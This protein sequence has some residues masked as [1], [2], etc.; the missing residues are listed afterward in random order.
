[1]MYAY[2]DVSMDSPIC[3]VGY[4]LKQVES[5]EQTL[6]ETGVRAINTN[7]TGV[8]G[9]DCDWCSMRGE[10]LGLITA[11]RAALDH[12]EDCLIVH[13]DQQQIVEFVRYRDDPFED[14]FQHALYSFLGRFE[15]YDIRY[16][17]RE[18]NEQAHELARAAL[19]ASRA[20]VNAGG[21]AQQ[22][23]VDV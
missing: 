7:T 19:Q 15:N 6:L 13:T 2:A 12:S 4:V 14:Y 18:Y 10:Y 17:P 23:S 1:M 11:V 16:V 8:G 21:G 20:V 22:V 5:G 9:E 3:A